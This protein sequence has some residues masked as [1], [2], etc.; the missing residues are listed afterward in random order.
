MP[1]TIGTDLRKPRMTGGILAVVAVL[2]GLGRVAGA[3]PVDEA[4]ALIQKGN[5]LRMA[6][7][8]LGSLPLLQQAYRINP[9]PRTA[10]HLGMAE[11]AVGRWAD[12]DRHLTEALK[13]PDDAW[14]RK[15][16]KQ[17][18]DSLRT[19]KTHV[20]RIEI[21]GD[22][23]GAEVLVNGQLVG[24]LPLAQP[25]AISAG[26]VDIELRAPGYQPGQRTL[27]VT[28]G[29]YQ[30][31]VIR[32]A[33]EGSGAPAAGASPQAGGGLRPPGPAAA[34]VESGVGSATPPRWRPIAIGLSLGGAG[35]GLA[36]G[37]YG[38]WQHDRQASAFNKRG[39]FETK[40]GTAIRSNGQSDGLCTRYMSDYR[41]ARLFQIAGFAAAG[42]LS[43]AALLAYLL[44][45]GGDGPTARSPEGPT[46]ACAPSFRGAGIGCTLPF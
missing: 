26:S 17:I 10:A 3:A 33:R 28:G 15:N 37:G 43:G 36:L 21:T 19:A 20:S 23:P 34:T 9:G 6:G 40:A 35:L 41:Q 44:G 7:D 45:S 31:V 14:V 39:C 12:A 5:A 25:I 46:L 32:L 22:P 8:D 4:N 38:T 24:R 27:S 16:H 13:S 11:Y 18:V 1:A 30:P 2:C 42:V 29:Q